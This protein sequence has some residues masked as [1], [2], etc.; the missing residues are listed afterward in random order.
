[1]QALA[2]L[3]VAD[4]LLA[5]QVLWLTLESEWTL[6]VTW[7]GGMDTERGALSTQAV[8]TLCIRISV[9]VVFLV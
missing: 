8:K 3:K 6:T 9:T 7:Q 2:C 4:I 5:K 1:M